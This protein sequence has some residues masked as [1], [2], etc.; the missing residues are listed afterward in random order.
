MRY[1][2]ARRLLN[3]LQYNFTEDPAK[4][5]EGLKFT[6][7]LHALNLNKNGNTMSH[8]S[9]SKYTNNPY[10][11]TSTLSFYN[12]LSDNRELGE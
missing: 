5:E 9:I 7:Q 6:A 1:P 10:Q 2:V 4:L 11:A 8:P 12:K 3:K